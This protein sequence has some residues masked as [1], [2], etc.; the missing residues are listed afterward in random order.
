MQSTCYAVLQI[1]IVCLS[2]FIVRLKRWKAAGLDGIVSEHIIYGGDQLYVHLCVL[3]NALLAH[4]FV[5]C[6]FCTGIIVPLLKSKH[7][8]ATSLDT[9]RNN[10]VSSAF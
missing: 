3:F 8:D 5:P 4:S 1:D 6:D 7:G 2:T 10:A 9:L